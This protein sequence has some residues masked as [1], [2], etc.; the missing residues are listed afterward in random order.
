M[1]KTI[2]AMIVLGTFAVSGCPQGTKG[3]ERAHATRPQ[4]EKNQ[5][6]VNVD[7]EEAAREVL[8]TVPRSGRFL[9]VIQSGVLR[10]GLPPAR[11]PFQSVHPDL[12]RPVGFNVALAEQIARVLDT[13]ARLEFLPHGTGGPAWSDSFDI[14]FQQPGDGLCGE[15]SAISGQW[16][17]LC[18]AE[19]DP[20]LEQAVN[21][22]L[23]WFV[24]TGMYT[25]LYTE[26]FP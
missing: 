4:G 16:L 13:K 5:G 6:P 22:T 18:V 20:A 14:V 1:R 12:G 8:D 24:E 26:Y 11:E 7:P 19:R 15:G 23:D 2:L 9:A 10:V 21:N 25:Y 3:P 17:T